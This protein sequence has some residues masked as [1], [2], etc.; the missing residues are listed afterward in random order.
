[1]KYQTTIK[2]KKRDKTYCHGVLCSEFWGGDDFRLTCHI[3]GFSCIIN[4]NILTDIIQHN[5]IKE[6]LYY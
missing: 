5:E 4:K 1:M 2:H 6:D 3:C